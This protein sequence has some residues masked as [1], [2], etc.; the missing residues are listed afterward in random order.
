MEVMY[1]L[2]EEARLVCEEIGLKMVRAGTVGT[3][4]RFIGMLRELIA[5]RL[6]NVE[7]FEPPCASATTGPA[8]TCVPKDAVCRDSGDERS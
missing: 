1:D 7:R 8:M 3:H 4:P 2:D 6:G 5:E